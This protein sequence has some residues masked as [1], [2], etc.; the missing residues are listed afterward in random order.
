MLQLIGPVDLAL[1][2]PINVIR[3]KIKIMTRKLHSEAQFFI[4]IFN[5]FSRNYPL[6][7]S[8]KICHISQMDFSRKICN[9]YAGIIKIY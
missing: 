2:H 7:P 1:D 6:N 9:I 5:Q 4:Q 8:E 3:N